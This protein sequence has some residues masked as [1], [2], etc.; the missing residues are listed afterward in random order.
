MR[1][2]LIPV[3]MAIIDKTRNNK[4]WQGCGAKGTLTYC[5]NCKLAQPLWKTEWRFLKELRIEL[6]YDP[7]IALMGIY[8]KNMKHKFI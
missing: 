6:L 7:V 1:Y 3:R 4:C 8:L 2:H 5:W